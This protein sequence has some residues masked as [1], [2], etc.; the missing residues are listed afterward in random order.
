MSI[1]DNVAF[2]YVSV[3]SIHER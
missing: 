2:V 1:L 3:Y